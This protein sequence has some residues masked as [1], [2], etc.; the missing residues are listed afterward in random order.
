MRVALDF[1]RNSPDFILELDGSKMQDPRF[2]LY[3]D[4]PWWR[5]KFIKLVIWLYD[6]Q[7]DWLREQEDLEAGHGLKVNR[8]E[9]KA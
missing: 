2:V 1:E 5:A 4:I 3:R 6:S 7:K 8:K 9:R